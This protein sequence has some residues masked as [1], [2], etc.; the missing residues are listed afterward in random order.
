MECHRDPLWDLL[1]SICTCV[2]KHV[3]YRWH[4]IV[5]FIFFSEYTNCFLSYKCRPRAS[6]LVRS[7]VK[8]NLFINSLRYQILVFGKDRHRIEE[9]LNI[10]IYLDTHSRFSEHVS[11]CIRSAYSTLK[12]FFTRHFL[13][14]PLKLKFLDIFANAC[15]DDLNMQIINT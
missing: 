10:T 2:N 13:Q 4:T 5:L 9:L 7:S 11:K 6:R 12:T 15:P 14:Q 8:H 3:K 1:Y